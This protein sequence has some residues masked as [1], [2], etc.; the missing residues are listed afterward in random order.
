VIALIVSACG[1]APKERVAVPVVP[2]KPH[3]A[4]LAGWQRLADRIDAPVYCPGWLPD[5]LTSQIK[6]PWNNIDSVGPDR[7]Y[8][9]SFVW[10]DT[11][12]GGT[13][14]VLHVNLLGY[15][16]RTKIP[17]CTTGGVES[18]TVPCFASPHGTVHE[19]GI[20]ATLYTVNQDSNTWHLLLLWRYAGGLYARAEH[21]AP[22]L[23]YNHVVL[24]LKHELRDLV[25]V[26][27]APR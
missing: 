4:Y 21:L 26:K 20:D 18:Q 24:Y 5:P 2:S 14:G 8:L 17:T 23:D 19:N 16:A 1:S 7:S 15:P 22:P 9:E 6:G 11:D 10:Q 3:C 13:S 12:L 27:P 25:L